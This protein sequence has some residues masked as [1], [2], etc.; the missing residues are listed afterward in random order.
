[1]DLAGPGFSPAPLLDQSA[2]VLGGQ[3]RR[4]SG[5]AAE[6]ARPLFFAVPPSLALTLPVFTTDRRT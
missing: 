4:P 6:R 3:F 2:I 1:M 5:V